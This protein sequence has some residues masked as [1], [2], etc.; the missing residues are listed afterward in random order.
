MVLISAFYCDRVNI[1]LTSKISFSWDISVII[2]SMLFTTLKNTLKPQ[3]PL[4]TI[5][6]MRYY[7][8]TVRSQNT[9]NVCKLTVDEYLY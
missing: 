1:K 8:L 3:F 2:P 5:Y 7:I 4:K 6:I 9:F